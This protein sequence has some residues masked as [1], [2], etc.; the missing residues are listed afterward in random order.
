MRKVE[1]VDYNKLW[2]EEFKKEAESLRTIM[3]SIL[4]NIHHIGSTSVAGLPAKPVIDIMPV[5]KKIEHVDPYNEAMEAIGYEAK[6]EH[7]IPSRRF[8]KKGGDDRTHHV[9]VFESG[10]PDIERHLAF[11]DY[12]RSHPEEAEAYGQL[13]IDLARKSPTDIQAYMD[14]KDSFIKDRE[15][16]ALAWYRKQQQ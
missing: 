13:K 7:G 8:F 16:R 14:G 15:R 6:G 11:R 3:E 9:H 1:V 2:P 12:M 10:S 4:M 5:V